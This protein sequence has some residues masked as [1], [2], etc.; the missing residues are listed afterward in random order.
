[1]YTLFPIGQITVSKDKDYKTSEEI[2]SLNPNDKRV[3]ADSGRL[4]ENEWNKGFI[5][6]DSDG[7]IKINWK[8]IADF[9][10]GR[11]HA[12]VDLIWDA[13]E[14]KEIVSKET[15]FFFFPWRLVLLLCALILSSIM[16]YT[17]IRKYKERKKRK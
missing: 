8:K 11:Y 2:I 4:F 14:G 9:R 1:M 16:L 10:I 5:T 15:S 7:S 3:F 17:I 6:R 12:K 13:Q